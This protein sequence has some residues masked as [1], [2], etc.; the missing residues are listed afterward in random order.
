MI[1]V[2]AWSWRWFAGYRAEANVI[3]VLIDEADGAL[4][5]G[6]FGVADDAIKRLEDEM[7]REIRR[8]G[9][10]SSPAC[11]RTATVV[12]SLDEVFARRWGITGEA[13]EVTHAR[14][15]YPQLFED[16]GLDLGKT[17][18]DEV[19]SNLKQHALPHD[20]WR[21]ST[22]GSKPIP[23]TRPSWRS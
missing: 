6:Q 8:A 14:Q 23:R 3:G 5:A 11:K 18:A 4:R 1:G 7:P 17:S 12:R 16:Y 22:P 13:R 21:G 9:S 10:N 2:G 15:A 19:A 20:Y